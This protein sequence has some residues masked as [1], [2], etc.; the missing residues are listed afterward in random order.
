MSTVKSQTDLSVAC[1]GDEKYGSLYG[2]EISVTSTYP[3]YQEERILSA[4]WAPPW[5]ICSP[6]L[7]HMFKIMFHLC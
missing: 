6:A 7:Q 2:G 4:W 1:F 5:H 3:R